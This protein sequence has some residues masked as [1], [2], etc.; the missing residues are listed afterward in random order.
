[1]NEFNLKILAINITVGCINMGTRTSR[2][3]WRK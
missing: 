3:L 1:M 2:D